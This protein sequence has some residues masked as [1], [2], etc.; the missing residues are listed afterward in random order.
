MFY[1]CSPWSYE[2][3]YLHKWFCQWVVR[4]M[5]IICYFQLLLCFKKKKKIYHL[6]AVPQFFLSTPMKTPTIEF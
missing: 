2:Y 5:G 6:L 1:P 4:T 3:E